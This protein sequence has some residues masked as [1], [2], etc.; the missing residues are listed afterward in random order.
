MAS[1]N[2]P[3]SKDAKKNIEDYIRSLPDTIS[4]YFILPCSFMQNP[5][6]YS[7]PAIRGRQLR[8]ISVVASETRLALINVEADTGKWVDRPD[9]NILSFE[10][11]LYNWLLRPIRT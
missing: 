8:L 2:R 6:P 7:T 11:S 1:T 5:D 4:K 9:I 3:S 10:M